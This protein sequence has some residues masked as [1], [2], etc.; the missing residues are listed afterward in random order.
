MKSKALEL[1]FVIS[2]V[3]IM[4]VPASATGFASPG[5][6]ATTASTG[7]CIT[8]NYFTVGFYSDSSCQM[9]AS[10]IL[11]T[12]D[13][14]YSS[15][16][17]TRTLNTTAVSMPGLYFKIDGTHQQTEYYTVSATFSCSFD[18]TPVPNAVMTI[19]FDDDYEIVAN[20]NQSNGSVDLAA[21]VYALSFGITGASVDMASAPTNL[22][23]TLSIN[24]VDN[25]S[26]IV[27]N[28]STRTLTAVSSAEVI[29]TTTATDS[30]E[31]ANQ[32]NSDFDPDTGNY[33][34]NEATS[35]TTP[36]GSTTVYSVE[37]N[38]NGQSGIANNS[39][40]VSL[41]IS[42]PSG[43]YFSVECSGTSSY[44][45]GSLSMNLTVDGVSKTAKLSST[46]SG[47]WKQTAF[48]NTKG[49]YSPQ[50]YKGGTSYYNDH[51]NDRDYWFYGNDVS[52][53]LTSKSGTTINS[54]VRLKLI[55]WPTE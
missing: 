25:N 4:T 10:N 44:G 50:F 16:G 17:T 30:V 3:I 45:T 31:E 46:S 13:I 42:M 34:I 35:Q 8:A 14:E 39:H 15:S 43:V 47:S 53:I 36:D 28:S 48:N 27:N 11:T 9:F 51:A 19:L 41:H 29:D 7:N 38:A 2:V 52:F 18:S 6:N 22:V 5:Y 55:L 37:I 40:T 49:V 23:I 21:G 12:G 54:D 1:V 33:H 26:G 20:S 24:V 32:N